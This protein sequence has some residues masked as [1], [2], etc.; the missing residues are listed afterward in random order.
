MKEDKRCIV[1]D[2]DILNLIKDRKIDNWDELL[3]RTG[4]TNMEHLRKRVRRMSNKNLLHMG[5]R[6]N[7]FDVKLIEDDGGLEFECLEYGDRVELEN[8][9]ICVYVR[10]ELEGDSII[11]QEL[12]L[13]NVFTGE[14]RCINEYKDNLEHDRNPSLD[15]KRFAN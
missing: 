2:Q 7:C 4:Y 9:D 10:R 6:H 1:S 15:I 3:E 14:E 12:V 13:I 8:G 11:S 5:N